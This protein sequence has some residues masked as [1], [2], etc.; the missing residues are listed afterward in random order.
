MKRALYFVCLLA[1]C[2]NFACEEADNFTTYELTFESVDLSGSKMLLPSAGSQDIRIQDFVLTSY[3]TQEGWTG[4]AISSH[5]GVQLP[6]EDAMY[7]SSENRGV[8]GSLKYA[9]AKFQEPLR[10]DFEMN[11]G[12]VVPRGI[13]VSNTLWN[14]NKYQYGNEYFV[15]LGGESG[16][17]KDWVRIE[18]TGLDVLGIPVGEVEYFL[19]DYR[20]EDNQ[21][22]YIVDKWD[23]VDLSPLGE[24]HAL[25]IMV[26]SSRTDANMPLSCCFDNLKVRGYE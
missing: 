4:F 20:F 9:V 10:I 15:P 26:Y 16:D 24:V 23:Y 13:F 1:M 7:T 21:Q 12:L 5:R 22:D 17:T 3:L 19:A 2:F 6:E 8:S 25:E 14:V 18:F 11:D